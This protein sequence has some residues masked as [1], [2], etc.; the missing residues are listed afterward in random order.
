MRRHT[1]EHGP[2]GGAP[3]RSFSYRTRHGDSGL[4]PCP[5]Q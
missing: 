4:A 1:V 2:R 3:N 5:R